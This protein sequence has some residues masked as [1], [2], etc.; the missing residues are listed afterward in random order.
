M[1]MDVVKV[2]LNGNV[3]VYSLFNVTAILFTIDLKIYIYID[4]RT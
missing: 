3:N 1:K 2:S 4:K